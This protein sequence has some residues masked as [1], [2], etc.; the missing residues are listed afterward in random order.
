ME[1]VFSVATV[2]NEF[3]IHLYPSKP[4][5]EKCDSE[6]HF[7]KMKISKVMGK[8]NFG[9]MY[10]IK[11]IEELPRHFAGPTLENGVKIF[12]GV[13]GNHTFGTLGPFMTRNDTDTLYGVTCAHVVQHKDVLIPHSSNGFYKFAESSPELKIQC[14]SHPEFS[15]IDFAAIKV[16]DHL[17]NSCEDRLKNEDGLP[18]QSVMAEISPSEL[19]GEVV[20]KYG[21]TT[22]FTKGTV[23]ST[24]LSIAN[25]SET[26]LIMIE[27]PAGSE[28][29]AR[30]SRPGDSGSAVCLSCVPESGQFANGEP[31]L[32]VVSIISAGDMTLTGCS[33][34]WTV[35]YSLSKAIEMLREKSNVHLQIP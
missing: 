20:Y 5:D 11:T 35:S 26:Y 7:A 22:R 33:E 28:D 27:P 13:E 34:N 31:H 15:L 18:R 3:E 23:V 21:A 29:D 32:K 1:E 8:Y 17:R 6:N 19:V 14:G 2:Y 12:N 9:A 10:K 4:L 30:F 24:D 25:N 16:V